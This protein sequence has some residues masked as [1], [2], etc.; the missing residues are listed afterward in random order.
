MQILLVEDDRSLASG[1]QQA[2]RDEGFSVNHIARGEL[3]VQVVK[4][5]PPDIVILDLGLPDIDGLDVLRRIRTISPTLAVLVLTARTTLD[6]KIKGL[7]LGADDYMAKPFAIAELLA[8]LR[9]IERRMSGGT[10][11]VI[12]NGDVHLDSSARTVTYFDEV[13]ELPRREYMLLKTLIENAG[14][15]Q[16]RDSLESKL[17]EWGAEVSSNAIEVHIHNLRK[18]FGASFIKT[19]RGVGYTVPRS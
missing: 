2:L 16:T 15:I 17:Y 1:L 8:R 7:D 4:T 12:S 18:K 19:V 3:A 5:E 14:K 9:A 6:E 10:S 11:A 13:I